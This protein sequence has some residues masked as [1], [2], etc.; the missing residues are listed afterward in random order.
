MVWGM[1]GKRRL[2]KEEALEDLRTEHQDYSKPLERRLLKRILPK[3]DS[4]I[5]DA[6]ED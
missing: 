5:A 1:S 6:E 2:E 3:W 4:R